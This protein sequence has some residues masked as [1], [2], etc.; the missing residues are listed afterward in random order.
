MRRSVHKGFASKPAPPS[1]PSFCYWTV[2]T[3]EYARMAAVMVESARRVGV[4]EDFHV[5]TDMDEVPGAVVHP[6]GQFDPWGW[7]FKL[8]FL[9]DEASKLPYDYLVFLDSDN[10]FVRHP[11]DL[12]S[13][14]RGSPMHITLEADLV[15][16]EGFPYWWEYPT[17][18]FVGLM[19]KAGVR[20]E[21]IHAV[22]AGMF[23]VK[24]EAVAE[25][26]RLA[27]EFWRQCK[28]HG[29]LYVDEPLLSYAMHRLCPETRPHTL[30]A[31][32]DLWATDLDGVYQS[33]NPADRPF[34]FRGLY[35]RRFIEVR[36][37]IVHAI[38]S[39]RLFLSRAEKLNSHSKHAR[40]GTRRGTV[41]Q[42]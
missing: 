10:W 27:D 19:R 42:R 1:S 3:G 18:V 37:A 32:R 38:R 8:V 24:R 20:H 9:K 14:L 36:P 2:A 22:N 4:E 40:S 6:A 16:E 12:L 23:I 25:V 35:R 41:G 5:W 21:A 29:V 31:T 26:Y 17:S 13:R 33:R 28:A 39:K 30:E 11:G 7:L 34:Q 15:A